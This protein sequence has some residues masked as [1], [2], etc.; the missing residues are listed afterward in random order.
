M[1]KSL[2]L[3]IEEDLLLAARKIA[4]ERGT[5]V[6]HLVRDYLSTLV[7]SEGRRRRAR[8]NLK[9]AFAKGVVEVGVIDWKREDLY[10]R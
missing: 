10:E 5:S 3:A 1:P 7:K 9:K 8:A 6:N 2:T 4:L